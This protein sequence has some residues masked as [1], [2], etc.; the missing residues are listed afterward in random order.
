[1]RIRDGHTTR[2][3]ERERDS[4]TV[5]GRERREP[6]AP[7]RAIRRD[8][9]SLVAEAALRQRVQNYKRDTVASNRLCGRESPVWTNILKTTA[10]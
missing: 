7:A 4:S 8:G 2:R 9:V 6:G 10:P 1:M 3:G 5:T